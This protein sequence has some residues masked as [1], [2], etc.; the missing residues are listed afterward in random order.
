MAKIKGKWVFNE[1]LKIR[2]YFEGEHV[3]E[4]PVNFTVTFSEFNV[5]QCP[6]IRLRANCYDDYEK[7]IANDMAYTQFY[8]DGSHMFTIFYYDDYFDPVTGEVTYPAE[9]GDDGAGGALARRI[10]FGTTEQ[11]VDDEFYSWFTANAIPA[12]VVTITYNGS[13]IAT[14][15]EGQ[16]AT[17]S[18]AGKRMISD[19]AVSFGVAGTITYN[20]VETAV[21]EGRTATLLCNGKKMLTDVVVR[22]RAVLEAGLYETGT[23]TLLKSWDDLLADG[24]VHVED[25]VVYTNFEHLSNTSDAALVGDLVLPDDGSITTIGAD[26]F[27]RCT[28]LT[29][30]VIP[31]SVT[32]I[33][34]SAFE[35]CTGLTSIVIPDGVTSIVNSAFEGCTAL[36]SIVIPAG[37]TS[38]V[39]S[40]FRDCTNLT[41]VAFSDNSQLAVIEENAFLNCKGLTSIAIPDSVAEIWSM[42]FAGCINL[43]E[44]NVPWAEGAVANAPWGATNATIHYNYTGV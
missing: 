21:G 19:V 37:V 34:D 32:S 23:S 20:G 35:G 38:I 22:A 36:T 44:I 14:L 6:S 27:S 8:S 43:T 24:A 30:I 41:S 4:Y 26:A 7:M 1:T 33:G 10:D 17:L 42:A 9:W 18:C 2:D 11:E 39:N 13:V 5:W 3:K 25:G 16:T 29:S 28:A 40:T 15:E 12:N 31:G